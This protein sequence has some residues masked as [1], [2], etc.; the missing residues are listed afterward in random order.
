MKAWDNR[1]FVATASTITHLV[2]TP[3]RDPIEEWHERCPLLT[4]ND[5]N[6]VACADGLL[7]TA[8]SAGITCFGS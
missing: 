4:G 6:G 5:L 1:C 7:V 2:P 8:G 3:H